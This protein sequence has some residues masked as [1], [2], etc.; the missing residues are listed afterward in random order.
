MSRVASGT[1]DDLIFYF[2]IISR[3][4]VPNYSISVGSH[5]L[6][7]LVLLCVGRWWGTDDGFS[8]RPFFDGTRASYLFRM[9]TGAR[10]RLSHFETG[11][12][13]ITVTKSKSSRLEVPK[14]RSRLPPSIEPSRMSCWSPSIV[15]ALLAAI[16]AVLALNTGHVDAKRKFAKISH[17]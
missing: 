12:P 9:K 8:C 3:R 7:G 16:F 2:Q 4:R 10:I 13:K 17:A 15:L 5:Q 6:F 11:P 1:V 14:L